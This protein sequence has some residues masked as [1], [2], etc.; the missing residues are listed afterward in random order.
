MTDQFRPHVYGL[1]GTTLIFAPTPQVWQPS[2]TP[3]SSM[4]SRSEP[5]QGTDPKFWWERGSDFRTKT[6]TRTNKISRMFYRKIL[7]MHSTSASAKNLIET[8][9]SNQT[10]THCLTHCPTIQETNKVAQSFISSIPQYAVCWA[11]SLNPLLHLTD[12]KALLYKW[13]PSSFV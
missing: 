5:G 3:T 9:N 6:S 11:D 13:V 2:D 1:G 4:R 10:L 8:I 7:R 12:T